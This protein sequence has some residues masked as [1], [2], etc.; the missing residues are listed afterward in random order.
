MNN[1][2]LNNIFRYAVI[3]KNTISSAKV[4]PYVPELNED[5][6][7]S[8]YI[9]RYFAQKANDDNSTIFEIDAINKSELDSDGYYKTTSIKWRITGTPQEIID[10]NTASI[11]L[12]Y[13]EMKN[14]KLYLSNLLQFAKI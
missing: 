6:Y 2:N 12:V 1:T 7:M 9:F 3:N 14:L 11:K 4:V 13:S 5:A 10:S 8:G